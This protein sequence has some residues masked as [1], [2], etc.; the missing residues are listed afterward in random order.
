METSPL[1]AFCAEWGTLA[2]SPRSRLVHSR[3][4]ELEPGVR[5]LATTDLGELVTTARRGGAALEWTVANDIVRVLI[6]RFDLDELVGMG[7]LRILVPGLTAIGRTMRWGAGGP[8]NDPEEFGS[9]LLATAWRHLHAHCGESL[10]RPCRTIVGQVKR[11]FRTERERHWRQASRSVPIR[12]G[13]D[14]PEDAGVDELTALARG[15]T[16]LPISVVA[17]RDAALIVANRVL[18]FRLSE[19]A[20]T[21]GES[22]AHLSYRRRRAEEA[23]CR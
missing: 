18:G 19:I 22:V 20:A 2:S 11:T 15:I 5:A 1:A 9:D 3:L 10:E 4:V 23:I 6:R 16:L 13:T 14:E 7:A 21:S 8:W 17:R 12:L